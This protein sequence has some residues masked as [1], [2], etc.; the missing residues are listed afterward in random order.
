MKLVVRLGSRLRSPLRS[1]L[2]LRLQ[3]RL[4]AI[5]AAA[6]SSCSLAGAAVWL[7]QPGDS[8]VQ[9]LARAVDGD[10]VHIA[11]GDHHAQ[12]AVIRHKRLTLRGVA[13][14]AGA[15]PVLH[16]QGRHAEGKGTLVIRDG[17]I[18]I[19]NIEFRGARVPDGNGAGIRF[20][21][22]RLVVSNCVFVDN[23]NGILSGN[24]AA[25]ELHVE[26]SRFGQAPASSRLPHLLYVG[27]IARFTL[28]GSHFSGGRSAHLVKSR[29]LINHVYDNRL[30]DGPRGSAAYELEFPNGGLAWVVGNVI[31]QSADTTNPAIVS[32]GAEGAADGREHGLFM[33]HNTLV[34]H[35][36]RPAVF[37]HLHT[38]PGAV[39]KRFVNNLSVGLGVG[40]LELA[41]ASQGNFTLPISALRG[42]HEGDYALAPDSWLQG[43]GV[44]PGQARGVPLQPA[45]ALPQAASSTRLVPGRWS[46]GALLH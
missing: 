6:W 23:E 16:A 7:V 29:A 38:L 43:H 42:A 21:G 40:V 25:A 39:A 9:A 22:G 19:D 12:V 46:P 13:G 31:A 41:D 1:R 5:A 26:N 18:H 8:L 45:G 35:G 30:V 44:P 24:V 33:A 4:L 15:R 20:E 2:Q 36:L 11:G 14:P 28:T 17:D 27:R 37:V 34:S 3:L 10:S 32:F